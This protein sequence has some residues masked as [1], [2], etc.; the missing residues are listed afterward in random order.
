MVRRVKFSAQRAKKTRIESWD[1]D[2]DQKY[3]G[4]LI[5][6]A[7]PRVSNLLKE[8]SQAEITP[9]EFHK[10]RKKLSKKAEMVCDWS[11]ILNS[12]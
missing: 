4:K 12:S 3:D 9:E 2:R 10:L 1:R 7:V 11:Q 8:P 6:Q 5:A